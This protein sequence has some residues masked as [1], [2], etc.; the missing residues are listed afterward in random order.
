LA[1]ARIHTVCY[2][3]SFILAPLLGVAIARAIINQS[4]NLAWCKSAV[5]TQSN[6]AQQSS[7]ALFTACCTVI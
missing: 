7:N 4:I 1:V 5:L 6:S 2:A 3:Q